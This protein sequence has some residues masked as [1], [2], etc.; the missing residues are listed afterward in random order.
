[1]A[2]VQKDMKLWYQG[3]DITGQVDILRAETEDNSGGATDCLSLL[4]DHADAWMRWNPQKNDTI[5]MTRGGYDTKTMYLH[6]VKPDEG[7]YWIYAT[8]CKCT[9]FPAKWAS[10]EKKTLGSIMASCAG[11]GGMGARQF[12]ISGGILYPYLLRENMR[13]PAFLERILNR[14]GAVLKCLDGKFTAIGVT[15][16]QSI[17]A[18]QTL[19]VGSRAA[20]IEYIDRR[21]RSWSSVTIDTPFGSGMA[22][23]VGSNGKTRTITDLAV[24]DDSMAKRWARGILLTHNRESEVL[25]AEM[26]FNPG[27]TAMVKITVNGAD[28]LKGEWLVDTVTHD[29]VV[30][31]TK[32]RMLRC[33]KT[34]M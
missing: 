25:N 1:M 13:A 3:K 34:V 20:K 6:T 18:R 32:A 27:Y 22:I 29:L 17:E 15:Y 12:G 26:E 2:R 31:R 33:V 21:D 7:R 23:D 30:G 28:D 16:A 5:R 19:N 4:L 11:E 9:P 24:D 8:G 10:Y 14:E